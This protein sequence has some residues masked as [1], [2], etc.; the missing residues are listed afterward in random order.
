MPAIISELDIG[1]NDRQSQVAA[2]CHSSL[3]PQDNAPPATTL[4]ACGSRSR[5]RAGEGADQ[6]LIKA[7][8]LE[9]AFASSGCGPSKSACGKLLR[10]SPSRLVII[11]KQL[12]PA[13]AASA[14]RESPLAQRPVYQKRST[15]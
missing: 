11:S 7:Y 2:A 14:I 5:L 1:R 15:R 10:A 6:H 9:S 3:V 13:F 4:W 8:A 12:K